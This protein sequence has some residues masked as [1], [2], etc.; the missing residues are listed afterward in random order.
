MSSS[1][2]SAVSS[3]E[4]AAGRAA[5]RSTVKFRHPPEVLW[6]DEFNRPV[7]QM[8]PYDNTAMA[9]NYRLPETTAPT[10]VID[11]ARY[12]G[13]ARNFTPTC[14]GRE[15][16]SLAIV[17]LDLRQDDEV[18]IETT[19]GSSYVSSCVTDAIAKHCRWARCISERTRAVLLIH[20]FGFPARLSDTAKAAGLPVIEDCAYALGSQNPEGTIG[21][22]G[23]YVVYSFSKAL[24]MPFGGLLKSPRPTIGA[25]AL[26]PRGRHVLPFLLENHLPRLE[27]A[28][29]RRHELFE[30]YRQ[31]FGSVGLLPLFEPGPWVVP[32]SFV[33]AMPDQREAET[34]KPLLHKAGII[35]SVLYGGGGYFLPNHQSL[36]AAA[37]DYIFTHFVSA[38]ETV[39]K[40]AG[41]GAHP[42]SGGPSTR[43]LKQ[44]VDPPLC[45]RQVRGLRQ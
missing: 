36:S 8:G 44:Q 45:H 40:S 28:C 42:R 30:E 35:S 6:A 7:F 29:R 18:L 32:H 39:R 21:A 3:D 19:S 9:V 11:W 14:N 26:S 33:V 41:D 10:P 2:A 27:A 15:A 20:E 34:I 17:D 23:D 16:I 12:F 37:I 24:P 43:T 22:I 13:A 5:S 4:P 31:R 38:L 1:I 25:S